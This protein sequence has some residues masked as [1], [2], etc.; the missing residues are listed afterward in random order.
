MNT[1]KKFTLLGILALSCVACKKNEI[2]PEPTEPAPTPTPAGPITLNCS[3][4]A[5]LTLTNH[6]KNGVDY[7]V[8]CDVEFTGG[9][10]F[11]DTNV[12]IQFTGSGSLNIKQGGYIEAIGTSSKTITFE[13]NNGVNTN[14]QGIFVN[15]DDVRNKLVFCSIKNAGAFTSIS[16]VGA[17]NLKEKAAL[18]I[19]GKSAVVN[20]TITNS[21]GDGVYFG[22]ES[23]ALTFTNNV[24]NNN[25]R[26][27]ITIYPPNL[28]N[29]SL[30][31]CTLS[32]N[33]NNQIGLY[34]VSS[35]EE[36]EFATTINKA[37]IDYKALVNLN[38]RNNLDIKPGVNLVMGSAMVL[39]IGNTGFFK[40]IGT[41]AEPINIKGEVA[42]AGFWD[43]IFI[44]TDNVL[45]EFDY[46]NVS[47]GGNQP[48]ATISS[49]KANISVGSPVSNAKFKISN[50]TSTNFTGCALAA[51]GTTAQVTITNNSTINIPAACQY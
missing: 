35:N 10:L 34:S 40:A 26:Y 23:T 9:R 2:E 7:I 46:V 43:G 24:I 47:D 38:F 27:P 44:N 32:G 18:H 25:T 22:S 6:N 45:N 48:T 16:N 1:L 21:A 5:P 29:L 28:V 8:N 42:I 31:S 3:Y 50:S 15:S 4:N 51:C 13:S 49:I 17:S 14:W 36:V 19:Y 12:I 11:I 20:C 37:N 39:S 41:P 30:Q 33:T